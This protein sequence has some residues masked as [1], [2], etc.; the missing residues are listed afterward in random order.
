MR[1]LLD[2][3]VF[4]WSCL[5]PARLSESTRRLLEDPDNEVLL[6][7]VS[8][9]E[10]AIKTVLQRLELPE[11]P[12]RYVPTRLKAMGL[13]PLPVEHAHALRVAQLPLHHRDLFDRL[14][15][16]QAQLENATVATGDPQFLL[17]DVDVVWAAAGEPPAA[18]HE[19]PGRRWGRRKK[20]T[21]AVDPVR[22]AAREPAVAPSRSRRRPPRRSRA[23]NA[24]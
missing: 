24:K 4:L 14:L 21:P 5:T 13:T 9:W 15:V 22:T 2:T 11:P 16:A 19:R 3:H 10:I 1:I 12:T 18:V 8:S 23:R 20:S 17:Y 7:A 6:S